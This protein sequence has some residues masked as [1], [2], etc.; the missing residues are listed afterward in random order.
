MSLL[1]AIAII[2]SAGAQPA[3]A[4]MTELVRADNK[5][6][7]D[8]FSYLTVSRPQE[9]VFIS[10][11]SIAL[12]LQMTMQGA[13]SQTFD[14]MA[15]ALNLAGQ[16]RV[17][18]GVGNQALRDQ[19]TG[20]DKKVRLDIANSLWLRK[21][22]KLQKRFTSD[23]REYYSASVTALD[24]NRPDAVTVINNWVSQNTAGRIKQA[25][26][27][28]MPDEIMVLINAIYFKGSWTTAFDPKL[29]S[30]REFHLA[31]GSSSPRKMMRRDG[32]FRYKSD[33]MMQAVALP[34]GDGRLNMYVFLP[35]EQQG[36]G[37][38]IDRLNPEELAGL[39]EGF[40][41]KKGEVVLPRFK[42]EFEQSLVKVLKLL[43][44]GQAF[45]P[46]ADFS[47][48]VVPPATAA[49]SDVLHKTFVEVNE[50]GTEAAA[51]TVVKMLATS[52]PGKVE[53]F[54][55]VCDHPFLCAIRDDVTGSVL[56]LG[57]IFDPKQ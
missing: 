7:L 55:F 14:A 18:V 53:R 1:L 38:L 25:V 47:Q 42:I 33:E 32:E 56:F 15:G 27:Q 30:E 23:C 49:I 57:A 6:G 2:S 45:T 13:G 52:M 37:M 9:N 3:A 5:L 35:R 51:V 21:G 26:S 16:D 46:A 48:M 8:I 4:P 44:M 11:L 28:L 20:A 36:V 29:T 50:E 24:F 39:F 31:S 22:T 19:L 41:E 40:E 10:P 12:A 54:S 17:A 43:G 34:Y